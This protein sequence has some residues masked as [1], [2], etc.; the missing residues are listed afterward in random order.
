MVEISR[1]IELVPGI[2]S[3]EETSLEGHKKAAWR[4]FPAMGSH[5]WS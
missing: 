5:N 3:P 4:S 2:Y 1:D